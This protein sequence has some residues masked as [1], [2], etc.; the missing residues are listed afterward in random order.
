M[1]NTNPSLEMLRKL[2][3]NLPMSNGPVDPQV[4]Q[5]NDINVRAQQ[6]KDPIWKQYARSGVDALANI[7]KGLLGIDPSPDESRSGYGANA[8][9]QIGQALD[10]FMK[11]AIPLAATKSLLRPALSFEEQLMQMEKGLPSFKNIGESALNASGE[12][13]A[14]MEAMNRM[15]SM[16]LRGQQHAVFDRA[17]NKRLLLGPEA[18]DYKTRPGETYGIDSPTGF[19]TLENRGGR[20]K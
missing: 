13:A 6:V 4:Q 9:T 11:A 20:I 2:G 10:P 16:K 19:Q 5:Q 7:P 1:P 3:L 18:V 15:K 14:S 8:I 17:G 12:S